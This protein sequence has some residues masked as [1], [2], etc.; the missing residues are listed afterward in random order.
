LQYKEPF[1]VVVPA[2]LV[3]QWRALLDRYGVL[4]TPIITHEALSGR[5]VRPSGRPSADLV[6]IDEAHRFRNPDINR[7]RALARF[8]IGSRVLLVTATPVHN[9]IADLL[10]LL[11]LFLRDHS[12]AALGVHF[13]RSAVLDRVDPMLA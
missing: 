8:I 11:R 7:Y 1:S 13:L 2:V 4:D 10:H 5:A 3:P 12:L 9:R 6:V